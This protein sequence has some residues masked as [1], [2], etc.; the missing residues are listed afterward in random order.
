MLAAATNCPAATAA[1]ERLRLP[2]SGKVL[3]FTAA[4]ALDGTSL[5]SVKPKSAPVKV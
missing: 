4:S 2:A 1:P 5:G 3:I